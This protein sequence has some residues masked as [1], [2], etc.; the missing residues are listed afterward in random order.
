MES[1]PLAR[2]QGN[3]TCDAVLLS[4]TVLVI[5][6]ILMIFDHRERC[7]LICLCNRKCFAAVLVY[8]IRTVALP[9]LRSAASRL[10]P[11]PRPT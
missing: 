1:P 11:C 10:L 5:T 8:S 2:L 6:G 4:L 3:L 7:K 9:A